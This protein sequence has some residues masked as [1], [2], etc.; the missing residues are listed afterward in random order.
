MA[1][2]K[3][4]TLVGAGYIPPRAPLPHPFGWFP[5][6][7]TLTGDL[8]ML[9]GRFVLPGRGDDLATSRIDER[10]GQPS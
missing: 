8:Q 6:Q 5:S 1:I 10:I 3:T 2:L 7:L 4:P 9:P